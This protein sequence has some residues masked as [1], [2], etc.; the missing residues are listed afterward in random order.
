LGKGENGK[1]VVKKL[2][3]IKWDEVRPNG[4]VR[5]AD[6]ECLDSGSMAQGL[7]FQSISST[8][9]PSRNRYVYSSVFR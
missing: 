3:E 9:K 2:D 4:C 8:T 7:T 1:E 6:A 5:G